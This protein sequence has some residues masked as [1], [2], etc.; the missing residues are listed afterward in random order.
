[1][2]GANQPDTIACHPLTGSGKAY[3]VLGYVA[4]NSR[5]PYHSP[6]LA[7]LPAHNSGIAQERK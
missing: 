4:S 6:Y 3:A 7:A 1:M 2:D 5:T